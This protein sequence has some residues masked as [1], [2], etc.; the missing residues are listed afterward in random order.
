MSNFLAAM[1][2]MRKTNHLGHNGVMRKVMR[3][4]K[5]VAPYLFNALVTDRVGVRFGRMNL[6]GSDYV[7]YLFHAR[8]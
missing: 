1:P 5:G 6:N 2:E 7:R 3:K 4:D 8:C